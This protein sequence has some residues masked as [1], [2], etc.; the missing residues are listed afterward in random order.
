MC[1]G[2]LLYADYLV[3]TESVSA[4]LF[5]LGKHYTVTVYLLYSIHDYITNMEFT[6]NQSCSSCIE[7]FIFWTLY[8]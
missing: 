5:G 2:I 8:T 1:A 3:I 6:Y 7:D 4:V